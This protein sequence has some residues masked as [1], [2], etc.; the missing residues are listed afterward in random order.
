V[1]QKKICLLGASGVGK[2]SLVRRFVDS[3]FDEHYLTTIGAKVDKRQVQLRDEAITL[4]LWDI[5]GAEEHFSIPSAYV[6][7]AA[8][9]LL[10]VDATRPETMATARELTLQVARDVGTIPCVLVVNK[11]DLPHTAIDPGAEDVRAL[12]AGAV[13]R[14]S[15]KT[16]EG[17]EDAF[18]SLA[19]LVL[20]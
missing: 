13:L 16:G 9:Y 17:V 4:M 20:D 6:R 3:L 10:V 8:G 19:A 7:G 14:T 12:N 1:I 15:A 5:A 11:I 2:T 18:N